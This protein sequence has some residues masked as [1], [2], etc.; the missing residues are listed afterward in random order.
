[1][2]M[3][4]E[5]FNRA[6]TEEVSMEFADI[7]NED[8]IDVTFSADFLRKMDN[9]IAWQKGGTWR[10]LQ[11]MRKHVAMIAIIVLGTMVTSCGVVEIVK[12]M[13][14]DLYMDLKQEF[15]ESGGALDENAE[16]HKLTYVPEG[17][18][19]SGVSISEG[20]KQ[21]EYQNES[22]D[23]IWFMQDK[24]GEAYS[25][26]SEEVV[27]SET[28][29]IDGNKV[30]LFENN[31]LIGAMWIEDGIY[32]EILYFSGSDMEE[33]KAIVEGVK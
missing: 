4:R 26:L 18:E 9:L 30:V 25:I 11:K 27:K 28:V 33:L 15:L 17:Y 31:M 2:S 32:I 8:E 24:T 13:H 22:Y 14:H 3:T 23:N 10:L 12:N 7:P 20:T 29:T 19:I 6:F 1:M 16:F 5:E 21:M